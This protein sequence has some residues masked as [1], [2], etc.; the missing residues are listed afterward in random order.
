MIEYQKQ[1]IEIFQK[2]QQAKNVLLVSHK[3]PDGD[4]LGVAC[5]LGCYLDSINKDYHLFNVD[6][7]GESFHYLP[8]V[9]KVNNDLSHIKQNFFDLILVLDTSSL[10][11][12]GIEEHLQQAKKESCLI[13]IDHHI[14]NTNYGHI[15]LVVSNASSTSEII[16][17]L[18]KFNKIYINKEMANCLLTGIMADSGNFSNAATTVS[19]MD[20]AAQLLIRGGMLPKII[21]NTCQ[22]R[23]LASLK[24][25]G[26]VLARLERNEKYGVAYTYITYKDLEKYEVD[27]EAVEGIA[28]FLN[29]LGGSKAMIFLKEKESGKISVSMRTTDDL[30]DVSKL[31]RMIGGGGHKKAAGFEIRGTI[32][33]DEGGMKIV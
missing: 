25:W 30:I 31:A 8:Y 17:N 13:N 21:K 12:C 4:C 32:V 14:S 2:I 28:N 22:N 24:L 15:N 20:A 19:S 29:N 6:E 33:E 9:D 10:D 11:H 27:E 26:E 18:F 5:S 3:R 7:V 23:S 1:F 16:Y